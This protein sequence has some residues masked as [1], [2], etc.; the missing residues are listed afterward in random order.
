MT[1]LHDPISEE[2]AA[3][4]VHTAAAVGVSLSIEGGGTRRIGQKPEDADTL[5]TRNLT[6]IVAYNPAEMTMTA[7][8]GTPLEEIDAALADKRQV[9]AFEPEHGRRPFREGAGDEAAAYYLR[10]VG[11]TRDFDGRR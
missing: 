11:G 4:I 7:K 1:T 5:S 10:Q 3:H 8:A 9:L 2:A 6:G